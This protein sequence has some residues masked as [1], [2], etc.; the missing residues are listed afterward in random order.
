VGSSARAINDRNQVAG[1]IY[2]LGVSARAVRWEANGTIRPLGP[3][4]FSLS[5]AHAINNR[6]LTGGF[7]DT[8]DRIYATLWDPAGRQF[9]LAPPGGNLA[10]TSLLNERGDAAGYASDPAS[11]ST[12]GFFRSAGGPLVLTGA[13]E[14]SRR[15]QRSQAAGRQH[16]ERRQLLRVLVDARPGPGPVA[17]SFMGRLYRCR[18]DQRAQRD[19]RRGRRK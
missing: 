17:A 13:R 9:N 2:A 3:L 19:R 14:P 7:A 10:F 8:P 18:R 4:P 5:E 6:G 15:P 1:A 16:H 12:Q 11:G